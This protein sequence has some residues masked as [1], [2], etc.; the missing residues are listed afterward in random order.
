MYYY[1]H[2]IYCSYKHI[3]HPKQHQRQL[4]Q[5]CIINNISYSFDINNQSPVKGG[6]G[7]GA[8]QQQKY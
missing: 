1:I 5:L 6:W 8:I 7:G 2:I 4:N 3:I